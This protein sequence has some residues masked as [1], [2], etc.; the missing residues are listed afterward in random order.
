MISR[1]YHI[2]NNRFHRYGGRGIK[3]CEEWLND[4][5]LFFDWAFNNGYSIELTLDRIDVN[6]DYCPNNCRWANMETQQN[7]RANTV[8]IT[9]NGVSHTISEWSKI[10][11]INRGTIWN[12]NKKGYPPEKILGGGLLG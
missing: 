3:V 12:R 10:T 4:K 6:G 9:L 5:K 2:Q 8:F 7:N 1:C 11:G